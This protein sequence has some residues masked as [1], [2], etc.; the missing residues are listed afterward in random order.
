LALLRLFSIDDADDSHIDQATGVRRCVHQPLLY[1]GAALEH[2]TDRISYQFSIGGGIIAQP[3]L[4]L[5]WNTKKNT[6]T[7]K[8]PNA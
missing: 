7:V 4:L 6:A 3:L 1:R 8:E 2:R 5:L